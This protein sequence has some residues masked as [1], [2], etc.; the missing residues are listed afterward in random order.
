MNVEDVYRLNLSTYRSHDNSYEFQFNYQWSTSTRPK[1]IAIREVRL[2]TSPRFLL[3][4]GMYLGEP[5]TT[6]TCNIDVP[7]VVPSGSTLTRTD[8]RSN[9][10]DLFT[11]YIGSIDCPWTYLDQF[12]ISYNPC[13][14]TLTYNSVDDRNLIIGSASGT[15]FTVSS[16]LIA[17]T[18]L[19]DPQIWIDLS[20]LT[21]GDLTMSIPDVITGLT[22]FESKWNQAPIRITRSDYGVVSIRFTSVWN[23]DPLLLKSSFVDLAYDGYLGF[24]NS[25]FT[26]PKRY[27]IRS[28]SNKFTIQLF[29]G[30]YSRPIV[31]PSDQKDQV[32]IEAV[33]CTT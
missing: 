2:I 14:T 17:I 23:R 10:N 4:E 28:T 31:L 21:H 19:T 15:G 3:I 22:Q 1:T 20:K 32:V 24:T 7:I 5:S 6:K 11:S 13:T 29:D 16:D 18:G 12:R 8:F 9:V 26:P 25:L 27:S 30:V 33:M